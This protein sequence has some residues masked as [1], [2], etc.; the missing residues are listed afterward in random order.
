VTEGLL[1]LHKMQLL[2]WVVLLV[3]TSA[4]LL[5]GSLSFAWSVLAGGLISIASFFLSN[6]DI[7]RLIDSV[8]SLPDLDDRKATAVQGQRGYLLKFWLRIISI[9]VVLLVLI[10]WQLVNIFGLILGLSTVV[11]AIVFISINVA[12]HY[13]F[14]GRR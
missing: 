8:V 12:V 6:R 10:K 14:R 3:L 2:S 11:V 13:I 5:F 1:S 7:V 4:A 9:A